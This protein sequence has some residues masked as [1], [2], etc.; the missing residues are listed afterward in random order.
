METHPLTTSRILIVDDQPA[1]VALLEGI[2]DEEDF[3]SYRSVL[4]SRQALGTFIEYLPDIVLLDLQM[5][6]MD[7]F[8]VMKQLRACIAPQDFLPILVLTADV[9][10]QAK[11]RALAEGAL[12]FLTKPFDAMEVILRIRNLLQTRSLHLQLQSRN[13]ILDHKVR[14]RTAELEATQAEILERL[15]LAAEYRDDDTGEHTRRV[16]DTAARIAA[17]LGWQEGA[18]ELIRRAA[19]LHDVGKIAISDSILLKPGRLTPEEFARM[20]LHTELGA[21]MLSGGQF[22]LMQ[23]AQ[24]I[25]LTHHERWD[26][27]GYIGLCGESIP[28]AGRIVTVSDV[29]DALISERVYKNAWSRAR[30]IEEIQRQSGRQ[31]DPR[32]VE[33]FLQV[34]DR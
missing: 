2:L 24:E 5:P 10:P 3:T 14:E 11:R 34:V 6:F 20:K 8:D 29:F 13:E 21:R 26:G 22:P 33:A 31:F 23:L 28:M 27:T 9:T 12:D 1:N 32:V 7:G 19:P 4:D 15:A 30:A 18:I 17:A 16:G 25:A